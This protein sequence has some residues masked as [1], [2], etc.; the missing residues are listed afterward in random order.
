MPARVDGVAAMAWTGRIDLRT[1]GI[2]RAAAGRRF[3][4]CAGNEVKTQRGGALRLRR[5]VCAARALQRGGGPRAAQILAA[6]DLAPFTAQD[7]FSRGKSR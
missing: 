5:R 4:A 1:G 6:V 3:V 7:A 2:R